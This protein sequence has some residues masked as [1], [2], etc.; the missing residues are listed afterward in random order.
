VEK[1]AHYCQKCSAAN[2]PGEAHC[3]KC[4]TRLML[5]VFPPSVRHEDS[6]TPSYY[7]DH[8]LERVSLLELRLAQVMD[9]LGMAYEFIRREAKSF[10]NDHTLLQSF[11]ETLEKVN[12]DF[13]QILTRECLEIYN[14][15][16]EN[17]TNEDKREDDLKKILSNHGD[18][19]AE[20]FTHLVKE[21]IKLLGEDEE[22]QAF[23]NLERAALLSPKNVPLLLFLTKKLFKADKF[24]AAKESLEKAFE[25]EPQNTDVLLLLGTIYADEGEAEKARKLLSVLANNPNTT[26]CVNY[27]WGILAAYERNWTESLAAFKESL[28]KQETPELHYLI[29]CVYWQLDRQKLAESHFVKVVSE[30]LRFADA[31]FM[32]SLIYKSMN[33]KEKEKQARQ[34]AFEAKEAGA[35]CL[36]FMN[37]KENKEPETALPFQHF[38]KPNKRLLTGGSLRLNKFLREQIFNAID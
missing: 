20:L 16:L 26:V 17:L 32:K 13:S 37:D 7:E 38:N 31:W 5:V 19:K 33:K 14:E 1:I 6:I 9:Q 25:I 3:Y 36:K 15:K 24:D 35:Q 23:A 12:P 29:G 27:I 22:K 21:G 18:K 30:D 34:A 8:L 11:F 2:E 4:G 10:Q 28:N